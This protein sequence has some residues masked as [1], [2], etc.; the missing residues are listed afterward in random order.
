MNIPRYIYLKLRRAASEL[1]S[2]QEGTDVIG[3]IASIKKNVPLRGA[4][5]W[6][7][8]C[9]AML[10]SIGLDVPSGA[11]IIGAMLISPLM[12]PIL[13]I[14]LG[15][16]ISDRDLIMK[17][18]KSFSTAVAVSL[19]AS[20]IYF[21]LTPLG[22][23]TPELLARTRPTLL[24]VGVAVFGGV[25]GIVANSRL[26]KTSVIPGVAIATALM[27]PLCTAGYG[28]AKGEFAVFLGAFYLFFINAVFISLST[29]V[30]VRLLN[31]PYYKFVDSITKKKIQRT[32]AAVAFIVM[33]PSGMIF[34]DVITEARQNKNVQSFIDQNLKNDEFEAIRWETIKGD[35]VDFL[36]M[37]VIG[38]PISDKEELEIRKKMKNYGLE[39]LDLRIVQMNVPEEER[40]RIKSEV[41]TDVVAN[42]M[43]QVQLNESA[44]TKFNTELD[45]LRAV[46]DSLL[47]PRGKHNKLTQE[48]AAAFPEIERQT[49]GVIT[50]Y[51]DTIENFIP[52]ALVNYPKK[53][54]AWQRAEINKKYSDFLKIRLN[55][56]SVLVMVE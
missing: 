38:D 11:V 45:S 17:A 18:V 15:L 1:F 49:F 32:I 21:F 22:Q 19:V 8:V 51:S 9:A 41:A 30:I 54:R 56:D 27:P 3:T 33:I 43:A 34:Y 5:I 4:N 26:E 7:L 44:K 35:S 42:V 6:I 16:G 25:A 29:Y 53:V 47:M 2:L 12:T 10:A 55:R 37:F 31:F 39:K 24:D 20:T 52:F 48:L 46:M 13:G 50:D 23:L 36:K 28:I 14:G 40:D